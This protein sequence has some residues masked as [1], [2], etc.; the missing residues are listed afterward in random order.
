MLYNIFSVWVWLWGSFRPRYQTCPLHPSSTCVT[1]SGMSIKM[2]TMPKNVH[3]VQHS[4]S[5]RTLS[6]DGSELRRTQGSCPHTKKQLLPFKCLAK[7]NQRH[8]H[9]HNTQHH[10]YKFYLLF[11]LIKQTWL[12]LL[13]LLVAWRSGNGVGRINE[14]TLRRARLVPGWVK[15]RGSTPGGGTLFRYVTSHPGQ[16]CLSSFRG[17]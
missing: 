6:M 13:L 12:N 10:G 14:V 11:T 17:R 4:I 15:C 2:M 1:V 7:I 8:T 9:I 3:H 16:L 5:R